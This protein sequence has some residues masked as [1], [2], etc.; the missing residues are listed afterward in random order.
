MKRQLFILSLLLILLALAL[1]G[2]G[3]AMAGEPA[4]MPALPTA[5][6]TVA[7]TPAPSPAPVDTVATTASAPPPRQQ[8]VMMPEAPLLPFPTAHCCRGKTLES[9]QYAVPSWLGISLALDLGEGWRVLNEERARLLLIGR[10]QNAQ[11]N[12]SQIITFI[13]A[14]GATDAPE[15]I[16]AAVQGIKQL[17][18]L[19]EPVSVAIAGFPGWQLDLIANPNPEEKGDASADIPPGIQYLPYFQRYF[20]PGFL[21]A[22]STPEARVRVAAVKVREQILLLYM[23]APAAEFDQFLAGADTIL[24]TLRPSE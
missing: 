15:S 16:I 12:P 4:T 22:T 21:W 14:T 5:A 18:P 3:R 2:C 11:N 24:W 7:P 10:G 17:T 6:A 23:E 9:G 20:T 1:S 19:G 13:N 8:L